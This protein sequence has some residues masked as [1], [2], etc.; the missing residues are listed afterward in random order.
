MALPLPSEAGPHSA[1]ALLS[2]AHSPDTTNDIFTE[3]V[4]RRPLILR[5]HSPQPSVRALRRRKRNDKKAQAKRKAR[6]PGSEQAKPS[7]P[8]AQQN[9]AK[10]VK[11]PKRLSA[12]EKRAMG[13]LELPKAEATWDI[14][15]GLHNLWLGYVW[16][17][18]G[19]TSMPEAGENEGEHAAK[20]APGASKR[21]AGASFVTPDA[22]GPM[23][24][25]ADLH[26]ALVEVVRCRCVS[27]VGL[28]GIVARDSK[29]ALIVVT[30]T[31]EVKSAFGFLCPC[32]PSTC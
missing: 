21:R 20:H 2:R 27:R 16:E 31:D 4:L 30:R 26:G 12:R 1:H 13:L 10:T 6:G 25:S 18:L 28:R 32:G 29:S 9:P 5:A 17:I 11:P 8:Q 22:A 7:G 23:L 3:R 15:A 14:M 19:L 24:A